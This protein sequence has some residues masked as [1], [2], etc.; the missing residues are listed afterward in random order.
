M[1]SKWLDI[2]PSS[3]SAE[4][5][6]VSSVPVSAFNKVAAA[7]LRFRIN[8]DEEDL[9]KVCTTNRFIPNRFDYSIS[10]SMCDG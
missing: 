1:K 10:T 5:M 9:D 6:M 3:F 8:S 4:D 7:A 2:I